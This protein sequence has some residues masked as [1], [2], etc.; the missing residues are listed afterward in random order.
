ML[1]SVVGIAIAIWARATLA[2]NWSGRATLREGHELIQTGPY[3][4]VRHP[5][6]TGLL[7]AFLG[8]ALM[9]CSPRSFLGVAVFL[10]VF[11]WKIR[12]ED[13]FLRAEF[14]AKF[15]DYRRRVKALVPFVI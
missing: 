9:R 2:D 11:V 4:F 3:A 8:T 5:I 12:M 7:L 13:G 6:Y 15:E 10:A 1:L 14:G